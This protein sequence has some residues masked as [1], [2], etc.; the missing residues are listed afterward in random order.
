MKYES[1]VLRRLFSYV[2][3]DG[4]FVERGR[5]VHLQH[6]YLPPSLLSSQINAGERPTCVLKREERDFKSCLKTLG[7]MKS[8]TCIEYM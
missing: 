5:E 6:R 4:I 2:L 3:E 7:Y 1:L 8:L